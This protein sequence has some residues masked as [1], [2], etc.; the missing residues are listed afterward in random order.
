M[1]VD[2]R[3]VGGNI[4]A[5]ARIEPF[6]ETAPMITFRLDSIDWDQSGGGVPD[7]IA[8]TQEQLPVHATPRLTLPGPD[9]PDY[10]VCVLDE[11]VRYRL[12]PDFDVARTQ[13]EFRGD[14]ERGPYL[15]IHAIVV[16]ALFQ[17]QQLHAG[18]RSLPVQVAFVIDNTVASDTALD[19]SKCDYI[20]QGLLTDVTVPESSPRT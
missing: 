8:D 15:V 14:D 3:I 9:R 18:M 4:T 1:V 19:F 17:G 6:M 10:V 5:P 2:R 12:G 11:P 13:P 20:G 7:A 16:C